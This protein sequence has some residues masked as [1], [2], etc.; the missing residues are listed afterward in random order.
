MTVT[1]TAGMALAELRAVEFEAGI[2]QA[3]KEGKLVLVDFYTTWCRDCKKMDKDT[4]SD[5]ELAKALSSKFVFVK[6]DGTKQSELAAKYEVVAYPTIVALDAGGVRLSQRIGYMSK[7]E[8]RAF[9]DYVSSGA[10]KSRS[11]ND[12]MKSKKK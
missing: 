3:K 1:F 10:Y 11:F 5:P 2:A 8:L 12:Y 4:L 6:V 7:D 9:M